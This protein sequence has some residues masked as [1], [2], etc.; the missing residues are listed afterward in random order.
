MS[1]HGA[2]KGGVAVPQ[3]IKSVLPCASLVCWLLSVCCPCGLPGVAG[4]AAAAEADSVPA[5]E[6]A[7]RRAL[8]KPVD[9]DFRRTLLSKAVETFQE[10]TGVRIEVDRAA[11]AE[12]PGDADPPVMLKVSRISAR[13][14]LELM[15][16]GCRLTWVCNNGRILVTT[17]KKADE[18]LD[19]RHYDVA[20]LLGRNDNDQPDFDTL[21]GLI[22]SNVRPSMWEPAG[23]PGKMVREENVAPK[24]LVVTQ[25]QEA[26]EELRTLLADL[27]TLRAKGPRPSYPASPIERDILRAMS[28]PLS[29]D[30]QGVT[31][32]KAAEML[33]QRLGVSVVLDLR[34]LWE[35][36]IS[37]DMHVTFRASAISARSVLNRMCDEHKLGWMIHNDVLLITTPHHVDYQLDIRVYDVV[38]LVVTETGW[39]DFDHLIDVITTG[40]R[41]ASWSS[42]GGPGSI[43][44]FALGKSAAL[45]IA[46][47]QEVHAEIA[48]LLADLRKVAGKKSLPTYPAKPA[49]AAI[50][51]ALTKPLDVEYFETPLSD[52]AEHLADTLKVPVLIHRKAL[53]EVNIR[54]DT[55]VTFRL[56][57]TS[58]RSALSLMLGQ[59]DLTW[60]IKDEV[61]LITTH[62]YADQNLEVRVYEVAD[63]VTA[64]PDAVDF[65]S[66]EDSITECIRPSTWDHAGGPGSVSRFYLGGIKAIVVAQ[67]CGVHEEIDLLL[68]DLRKLR[69]KDKGELTERPSPDAAKAR[70][71]RDAMHAA[72][73]KPLSIELTK[74]PL[75]EAIA[76]LRKKTGLPIVID[77]G[78]LDSANVPSDTLVLARI[79]NAP[80]QSALKDIL[81]P[82]KLD[83]CVTCESLVITSPEAAAR[84]LDVRVYDVT[85]RIQKDDA[86]DPDFESL[87]DEI[88]AGV[89]SGTWGTRDNNKGPGTVSRFGGAG[90]CALVVSQTWRVHDEVAAFLKKPRKQKP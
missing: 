87:I 71:W 23:G 29:V 5:T 2:C 84:C 14:A 4:H 79:V 74:E 12:G 65:N 76:V 35:S 43:G 66:L 3:R 80:L 72:L 45:V 53:D 34:E 41:P 69:N 59:L 89:A 39:D 73:A 18:V 27:C 22:T 55:P 54:H 70:K 58:G 8:T 90:L 1:R 50:A 68:A 37:P 9:L 24:A 64:A 21:I 46:Q 16:D 82:V 15:V 67:T 40:V 10:K 6:A 11:L 13:C 20:D 88:T 51:R 81:G 60:I 44:Q 62:Q 28:K 36:K 25:T 26:H 77:L 42:A 30:F 75:N 78:E 47:T 33:R 83:W 85:E 49:E 57:G 86:G 19:S 48:T 52:V 38:D 7:I 63:L 31:L 32:E 17:P 56:P 61:L